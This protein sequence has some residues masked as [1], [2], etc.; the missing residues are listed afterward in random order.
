MGIKH[1]KLRKSGTDIKELFKK[2]IIG[3]IR[4]RRQLVIIMSQKYEKIEKV[5]SKKSEL[6]SKKI[7]EGGVAIVNIEKH[8]I[9]KTLAEVLKA[10]TLLL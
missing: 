4:T 10:T 1:L 3:K 5:I 7:F 2:E 9:L 8:R 6:T